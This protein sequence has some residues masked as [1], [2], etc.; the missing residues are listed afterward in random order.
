MEEVR[1]TAMQRLNTA[2]PGTV[3]LHYKA[4]DITVDVVGDV[5]F[6]MMIWFRRRRAAGLA[7]TLDLQ[8]T[9]ALDPWVTINAKG[10]LAITWDPGPDADVTVPKDVL[11]LL[12]QM[13]AL[14]TAVATQA[15]A[16]SRGGSSDPLD[17]R[18]TT[19]DPDTGQ[20]GQDDATIPRQAVD[21]GSANPEATPR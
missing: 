14:R 8:T 11:A 12:G 9:S 5:A 13:E 2:V 18:E 6:R 21:P 16:A 3:T 19:G 7:D 10:L 15:P 4:R 20:A 17:N 1:A